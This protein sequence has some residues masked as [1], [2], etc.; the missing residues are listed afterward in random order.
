MNRLLILI[1]AVTLPSC[2]ALPTASGNPEVTIPKSQRADFESRFTNEILN[3][4]AVISEQGAN[5]IVYDFVNVAE[6][7]SLALTGESVSSRV[8]LNFVESG[9]S[10][11]VVGTRA[12]RHRMAFGNTREVPDVFTRDRQQ[13]QN[14]MNAAAAA[15]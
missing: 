11:R 3:K 2:T 5:F 10:V 9:G 15:R 12:T 8:R 13:I 4:N 7:F 14:W 6:G 1:L